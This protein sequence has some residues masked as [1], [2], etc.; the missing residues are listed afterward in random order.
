MKVKVELTGQLRAA[1]GRDTIPLDLAA[2]ATI[3]DLMTKLVATGPPAVRPHLATADG[4]LQPTLV[5]VIDGEALPNTGHR[6]TATVSEGA[7]VV[8]IPPV[9][10]G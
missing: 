4:R 1:A 2:G 10:G 7:T 8:L 5:V 3:G 9:A 6:E